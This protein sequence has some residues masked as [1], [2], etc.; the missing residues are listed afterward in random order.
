MLV[1]NAFQNLFF[2]PVGRQSA[3]KSRRIDFFGPFLAPPRI[4]RGPQNRQK[5]S[6]WCQNASKKYQSEA[7]I[8][9]PAFRLRPKAPPKRSWVPFSLIWDGFLMNFNGFGHQFSMYFG[10]CLQ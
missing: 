9:A 1:P 6:K 2:P 4:F 3:P 8:D 7:L 10:T 5:S